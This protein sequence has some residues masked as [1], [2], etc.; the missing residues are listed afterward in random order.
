MIVG[1]NKFFTNKESRLIFVLW[2]ALLL[3]ALLSFLINQSISPIIIGKPIRQVVLLMGLIGLLSLV[4]KPFHI[5]ATA[6]F[7]AALINASVIYAQYILDFL[8]M[9]SS[10]LIM[11][12]FNK[13]INVAFRKPGLMSGYPSAGMLSL[14]G[15][16]FGFW[17]IRRKFN[18]ALCL[19][20]ILLISTLVLTARTTLYLGII[21]MMIFFIIFF[22]RKPFL[23]MFFMFVFLFSVLVSVLMSFEFIHYDTINVMFEVFINYAETGQVSTQSS[24]ATLNSLLYY[25]EVKTF[26]IGNGYMNLTEQLTNIDSGYQQKLFGGGIFYF[27]L[28]I[29]TFFCY[30]YL[31]SKS[32]EDTCSKFVTHSI[33]FLVFVAD[34]KSGMIFAQ[35]VGDVPVMLTV[36]SLVYSPAKTKEILF[37]TPSHV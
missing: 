17:M 11:P 7:V 32:L 21:V 34:L 36:C 9:D 31:A 27:I 37:R 28:I 24:T 23:K 19:T 2:Y 35:V 15:V 33:F 12:S 10:W 6:V 22:R 26:L 5:V 3:I 14:Y 20:I 1:F 16:L 30:W 29:F 4:K 25:P 8:N 13:D 18:L